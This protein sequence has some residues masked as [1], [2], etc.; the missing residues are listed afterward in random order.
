MKNG[1]IK[2]KLGRVQYSQRHVVCVVLV[3][4]GG[5]KQITCVFSLSLPLFSAR[6]A[7][8]DGVAGRR[9]GTVPRRDSVAGQRRAAATS[10]ILI[11]W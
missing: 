7:Q 9:G 5:S 10:K 1:L 8:R 4:V 6:L 3:W 2:M 11:G